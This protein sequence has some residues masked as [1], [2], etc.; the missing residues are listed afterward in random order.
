MK[1]LLGA[2]LDS[3]NDPGRFSAQQMPG[4]FV[5]VVFRGLGV[6][7]QSQARHPAHRLLREYVPDIFGNY[8]RGDEI[9]G[10]FLIGLAAGFQGAVVPQALFICRRLH[11]HAENS[12][13]FVV[14]QEVV[15]ARVA[16]GSG[17]A[18]SLLHGAYGETEFRPHPAIFRVLDSRPTAFFHA[19]ILV[20]CLVAELSKLARMK[21]AA[22]GGRAIFGT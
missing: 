20:S 3:R 9:E 15:L 4:F 21:N 6:R 1:I 19:P 7:I 2:S 22:S 5:G 16:K 12:G 14:N 11:L 8:E 13:A 17:R 10:I 18:Q